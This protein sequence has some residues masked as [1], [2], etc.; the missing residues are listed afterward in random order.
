[1]KKGVDCTIRLTVDKTFGPSYA[2]A[3][4]SKFRTTRKPDFAN[5]RELFKL[6]GASLKFCEEY[7]SVLSAHRGAAPLPEGI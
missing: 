1:M 3:V 2:Y 5:I 6:V 7:A 4:D